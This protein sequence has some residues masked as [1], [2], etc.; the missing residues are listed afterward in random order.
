MVVLG[1]RSGVV[2]RVVQRLLGILDK[3]W[4]LILLDLHFMRLFEE[5]DF[6]LPLAR[7]ELSLEVLT[8]RRGTCP[9]ILLS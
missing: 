2:V 3:I 6:L 1:C 9:V 7:V 5:I 4:R 8:G